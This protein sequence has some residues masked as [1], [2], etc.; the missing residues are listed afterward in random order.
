MLRRTTP[1]AVAAALL[2]A[3]PS[4]LAQSNPTATATAPVETAKTA[5]PPVTTPATTPAPPATTPTVTTPATTVTTPGATATIT[6]T[7]TVPG[8]TATIVPTPSAQQIVGSTGTAGA[9]L[10]PDPP[11]WGVLAGVILGLGLLA[12]LLAGLVRW[13]AYDPP[14]LRRARHSCAEAAWR[15]GGTWSEFTDWVRIGR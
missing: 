11:V 1:L 3:A 13:R 4:A 9:D 14:W 10:V 6:T 15:L 12:A 5:T 2:V 8:S 7:T